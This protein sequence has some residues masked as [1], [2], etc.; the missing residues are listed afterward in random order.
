MILKKSNLKEPFSMVS[1]KKYASE[2]LLNITML[3]SLAQVI[4]RTQKRKK[5]AHKQEEIL[6]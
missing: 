4:D 2:Y 6:Y 3:Q 1:E 5:V